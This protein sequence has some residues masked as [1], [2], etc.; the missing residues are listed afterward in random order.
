MT[1]YTPSKSAV[2]I[3]MIIH[4]HTFCPGQCLKSSCFKNLI[5]ILYNANII[6][7]FKIAKEFHFVKPMAYRS[8]AGRSIEGTKHKT[9]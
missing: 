2:I 3:Q 1:R 6:F 4:N 9:R 5:I 8:E 7:F